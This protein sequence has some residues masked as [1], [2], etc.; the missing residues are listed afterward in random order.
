PSSVIMMGYPSLKFDA[1]GDY[2]KNRIANFVFGGAFNSRLNL[3]LR[4]DKGYTY[5]IRSAFMGN[6]YNG[7]F[8]I[9]ASVKRSATALSLAEIIKEFNKYEKDGITDAELAYTKSSLLNEEALNYESPW[10]KA[11]FLTTIS[12]YNLDKD[13]TIKQNQLLKS[14]TKDEVNQQIKKYFNSN[15]LTT[16]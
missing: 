12:R 13:F 6:K 3:N 11:S 10:Q 14:M 5:G 9:N 1:T 15:Q 7:T 8:F 2:Y 4:E 16:V